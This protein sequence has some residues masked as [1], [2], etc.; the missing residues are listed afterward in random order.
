MP[1][2]EYNAYMRRYMLQRYHRRMTDARRRLGGKCATC[3]AT[4]NLQFDHVDPTTKNFALGSEGAGVSE[5]RF[6]AELKLCQLL[7]VRCHTRKT[8]TEK[9]MI[10]A[11]GTHGT[12][13]AYRY[14]GPP[15][16]DACKKA[17]RE[18]TQVYRDRRQAVKPPTF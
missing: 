16:C 13:S 10:P 9:G 14:C 11:I 2:K 6:E 17:K 12:L 4:E 7:C 5:E 1:R 18:W 3:G 15:K 8:L